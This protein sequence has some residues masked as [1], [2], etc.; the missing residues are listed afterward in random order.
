MYQATRF[1]RHSTNKYKKYFSVWLQS[2]FLQ[3]QKNSSFYAGGQA[4]FGSHPIAKAKVAHLVEH[5]LAKVG[6]A[7]SSPVFRSRIQTQCLD[8]FLVVTLVTGHPGGGTG[9]RAGLKIQ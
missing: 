2:L 5:D 7:G 9:R 6:V 4:L 8:F 3:S 1:T